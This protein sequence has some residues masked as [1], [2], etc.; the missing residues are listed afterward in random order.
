MTTQRQLASP[1]QTL[2]I[3]YSP[4][5]ETDGNISLLQGLMEGLPDG[6]MILSDL[7]ELIHHNTY[8]RNICHQLTQNLSRCSQVPQRVWQICQA[9]INSHDELVEDEIRTEECVAIRIRARWLDPN[10]I[11]HPRL[12][13]TLEDQKLSAKYRAIAEARKYDLTERE[14]EVWSLRRAGL[15]YKAIAAQLH[16]AE[17]TVKKHIKSIHA[18]RDAAE[19]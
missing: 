9:L 18:K 2:S 16:I 6:I 11:E 12:L 5:Q 15:S 14:T 19:C 10:Y 7:G 3:D 8:A 17:D 13:V 1:K 4:T